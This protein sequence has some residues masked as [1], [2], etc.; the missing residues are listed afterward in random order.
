MHIRTLKKINIKAKSIENR[1][2][3]S[4]IIQMEIAKKNK[5]LDEYEFPYYSQ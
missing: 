1:R 4:H 3:Y 2:Q 5:S